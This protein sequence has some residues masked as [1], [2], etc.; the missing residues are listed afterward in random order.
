MD[1]ETQYKIKQAGLYVAQGSL[2]L[3]CALVALPAAILTRAS[4]LLGGASELIR[5]KRVEKEDGM[6][7]RWLDNSPTEILTSAVDIV[8]GVFQP[9]P[10]HEEESTPPQADETSEEVD[11]KPPILG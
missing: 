1:I 10:Q 11:E 3:A 5:L 6:R 9:V 8:Q 7:I 4:A 2:L